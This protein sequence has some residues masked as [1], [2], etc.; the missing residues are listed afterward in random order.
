[1]RLLLLDVTRACLSAVIEAWGIVFSLMA[2]RDVLC[3]KVWLATEVYHDYSVTVTIDTT[4]VLI[5]RWQTHA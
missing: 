3:L 5:K 2:G 4:L 1:M